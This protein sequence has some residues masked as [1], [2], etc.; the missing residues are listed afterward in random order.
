IK[1]Q[2]KKKRKTEEKKKEESRREEEE[3]RLLS[4]RGRRKKSKSTLS[5]PLDLTSEILS[6]IPARSVF[7]FCC[8]SKLWSSVTTDSY[9]IKSFKTRSLL[10]PSLLLCFIKVS[11]LF[12]SSISQHTDTLYK[13]SNNSYSFSQPID[14]YRME[15]PEE[16]GY[17]PPTE[18]VNGLICFP[19]SSGKPIVWNPSKRQYFNLPNLRLNWESIEVFL[20]YDP[21][22]GKHKLLCILLRE[23]MGLLGLV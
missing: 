19:R 4:Y 16:Y 14:R 23:V 11:T 22:Q 13:N 6:R 18:S 12:V 21:V 15:L 10:Q 2:E 3:E 20:G 1:E 17:F 5:F 8:V 9:F 7:R